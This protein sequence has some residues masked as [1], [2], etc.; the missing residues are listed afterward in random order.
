MQT[1]KDMGCREWSW[2]LI[3]SLIK[4]ALVI[5]KTNSELLKL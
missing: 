5:L 1:T 4:R 3:D 2:F